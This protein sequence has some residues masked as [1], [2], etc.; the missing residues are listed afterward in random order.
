MPID[1]VIND[2]AQTGSQAAFQCK[3]YVLGVGPHVP[4][5]NALRRVSAQ[6]YGVLGKRLR[7]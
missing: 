5:E 1:A 2:I 6:W 4:G 3:F 7:R